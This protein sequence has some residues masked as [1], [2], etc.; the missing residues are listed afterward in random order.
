MKRLAIVMWS[1]T[2]IACGPHVQFGRGTEILEEREHSPAQK[3]KAV[4]AN[5]AR[6]PEAYPLVTVDLKKPPPGAEPPLEPEPQ[7]SK[8]N[9]KK[10]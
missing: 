6:E 10:P 3:T 2:W 8:Q 5:S 4:Q 9:Q 7:K 1:A